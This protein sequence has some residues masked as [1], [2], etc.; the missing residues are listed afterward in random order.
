MLVAG[1]ALGIA[2]FWGLWWTSRRVASLRYP[3]LFF[4]GSFIVRMAGLLVAM[5]WLTRGK[6][7]E[8][9]ICMV[10]LILGRRIVIARVRPAG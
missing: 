8:V 5:F 10:G 9:A 4:T 1:F 2:Y 3:G 7:I 6:P